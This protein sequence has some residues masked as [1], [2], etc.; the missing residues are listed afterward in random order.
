MV[1]QRQGRGDE[2]TALLRTVFGEERAE[3]VAAASEGDS[4]CACQ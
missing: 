3:V 1:A 2:A 4:G